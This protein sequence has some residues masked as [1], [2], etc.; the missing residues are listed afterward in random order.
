[1]DIVDLGTS[2]KSVA[3]SGFTLN[4]EEKMQLQLALHK[5]NNDSNYD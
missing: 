5:L 4:L 1:M 2:L 3:S